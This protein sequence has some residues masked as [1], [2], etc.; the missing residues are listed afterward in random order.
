MAEDSKERQSIGA[1]SV[2]IGTALTRGGTLRDILQNCAEAVVRQLHVAFARIWV[3]NSQ[4]NILELVASA[5][6]YTHLDGPHGSVPVGKFKIGLIAEERKPHLTN[7]VLEDPRVGDRD[8]A[9]REGMV[10]FA[11]FPLIVGGQLMGVIAMFARH[12]LS[13]DVLE[14]LEPVADGVALSIRQKQDEQ[15]LRASEARKAILLAEAEAAQR[16]YR[17][18]AEAMPQQVWTARPDGH[19]DYLNRRSVEYFN[20]PAAEL[21]GAGWIAVVHPDDA[22]LA[23][24]KWT[25]ALNSGHE[26][27][28]E[29]RLQRGSDRRYRWHLGRAVPMRDESGAVL[30]WIGTNTDIHDRKQIEADLLVA[31]AEAEAAN[32]AKSQFLAS[33]SHELRTPLN[34]V[35][36]YSEMLQEEAEEL[37][38]SNLTPDLQ[39]IHRAGGYLLSLINNVLDLSKIEAGKMELFIEE[40]N[41]GE[42]AREIA[43]T[44]L[45]LVHRNG[46]RLEL[47]IA[48]DLGAVRSDLTKVRQ[49]LLN[50]LSNAAKFTNDGT[51]R[52]EISRAGKDTIRLRVSDSGTGISKEKLRLLFEPFAQAHTG[53][54]EGQSG[55]GLGL[56]ITRRLCSLMGGDIS[57]EST[58]G[59]GSAFTILLPITA[60]HGEP[61]PG[62][63]SLP[64]IRESRRGRLVLVVDDDPGSRDLMLWFLEREGYATASAAGGQEAIQM[65]RALHPSVITLDVILPD[66]DGWKVLRTLK[67][68]PEL[69]AI[70]V[71]MVTIIDDKNTGYGLGASEYMTK[72]VDRRRMAALL[73]KYAI[74]EQLS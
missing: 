61:E 52:L 35:I 50:L 63:S 12:K 43:E 68:D 3:L 66:M 42:A 36:G 53:R 51:V 59:K 15:S 32:L 33:M 13:P 29:F 30:R 48:P 49:C 17:E 26:Y 24:A 65:A 21:S 60:H 56:A 1:L 7:D 27:E 37:G 5:G 10:A 57:V 40:F 69:A 73:D 18:L 34:A 14:A 62:R 71:V 19:L 70:P 2:E 55:T 46:N 45:P 8:W 6:V 38:V 67:A 47:D 9:R 31:K 4:N 25:A 54:I 23:A 72:P 58:E 64:G 41:I 22:P 11:G 20:R 74:A 44:V 28:V 39:K 16:S